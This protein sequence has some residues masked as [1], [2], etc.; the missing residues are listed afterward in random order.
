[1]KLFVIPLPSLNQLQHSENGII[2][3]IGMV[4]KVDYA[5][6]HNALLFI[7]PIT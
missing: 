3:V 5:A 4:G 2:Q 1:M 6:L 7:Q